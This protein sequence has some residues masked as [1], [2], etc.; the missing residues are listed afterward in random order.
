MGNFFSVRIQDIPRE[1]LQ[2]ETEW[3]AET[4]DDM[5]E[6]KTRIGHICSPLHLEVS[7]SPTGDKVIL[8]GACAVEMQLTCV[9]CLDDFKWPLQNR[10]RYLLWPQL[11]ASV[12]KEKELQQDDLEV[13]YF[14]GEYIDLR[15]LV[16]EQI[17]LNLPQYPHCKEDC[18]GMC[19]RCGENL[20]TTPCACPQDSR[21]QSPFS[22]LQNLKDKTD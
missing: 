1:G 16:R 6:E 10:F 3:K 2:L 4:L 15:P 21:R 17:Y 20:N 8:E 7:F 22:V 19:S 13:F 12:S 9:R 11:K 5:L 18:L 14:E